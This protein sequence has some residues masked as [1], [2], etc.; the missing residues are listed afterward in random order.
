[1]TATA[2]ERL[3]GSIAEMPHKGTYSAASGA[4]PFYKGTL[5]V[6]DSA[7]VA[8]V[9][10]PG[11]TGDGKMAAGVAVSTQTN[12][13]AATGASVVEV[14]FGVVPLKFQGTTPAP[15]QLVYVVDNQ[16][17]SIT[18]GPTAA[19]GGCG[20]VSEVRGSIVY[21]LVGPLVWSKFA[22]AGATAAPTA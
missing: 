2:K 8:A 14:E 7:G 13:G 1:M 9:P 12:V 6:I 17:C 16:T 5:V 18:T 3:Y 11:G 20:I 19:R 10:T 21:V 15:G 4:G 22:A